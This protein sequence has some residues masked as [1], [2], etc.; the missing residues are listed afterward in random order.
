MIDVI[1]VLL[2][3]A[4]GYWLGYTSPRDEE[5]RPFD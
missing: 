5:K 2:T 4:I 3:L 1:L